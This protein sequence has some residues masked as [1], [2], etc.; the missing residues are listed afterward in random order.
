MAFKFMELEIPGVKLIKPTVFSD[1]RGFFMENYKRNDFIEAGIEDNFFQDNHS[2]SSKNVLRGLHYQLPPFAQSKIVR[3]IRGEIFDVAVDIRK[4]SP[5]FGKYAS[6]LLSEENKSMLYILE[7]F[8]HGFLA[9]SERADVL[10]KSS[11][12]YNQGFDRGIIWNDP[13]IN[14]QWPLPGKDC[15]LSAKDAKLPRLK[16]ADVFDYRNYCK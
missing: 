5:T 9:L 11:S 4:G 12:V 3:C 13:E 16:D 1:E 10:Y 7:G 15:I 8:A 6:V 2:S 14:I